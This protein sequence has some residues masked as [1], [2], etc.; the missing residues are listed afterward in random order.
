MEG[1]C[2]LCVT[3]RCEQTATCPLS[4]KSRLV[5]AGPDSPESKWLTW[6]C[7][8]ILHSAAAQWEDTTLTASRP[9]EESDI[10]SIVVYIHC[11]S[12][13]LSAANN[14][15][16][17]CKFCA[18][19]LDYLRT[20]DHWRSGGQ[21]ELQLTL[22]SWSLEIWIQHW[23]VLGFHWLDNNPPV[24]DSGGL[25]CLMCLLICWWEMIPAAARR[26]LHCLPSSDL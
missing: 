19:Q 11:H 23:L 26:A 17:F 13:G 10:I 6:F 2:H 18:N 21:T 3:W 7:F 25:W 5:Y 1:R 9:G 12:T 20:E 24:A 15:K 16:S 14:T 4:Y 8:E 22:I